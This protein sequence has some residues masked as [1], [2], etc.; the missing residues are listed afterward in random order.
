MYCEFFL[1][2]GEHNTCNAFHTPNKRIDEWI[3]CPDFEQKDYIA[4][5]EKQAA[6]NS[7]VVGTK[8]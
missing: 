2:L 7:R 5:K 6:L 8:F 4:A 3:F 1:L